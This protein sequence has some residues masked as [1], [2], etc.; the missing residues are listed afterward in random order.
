MDKR[1]IIIA[2]ALIAVLAIVASGAGL[3]MNGLYKN[4]T[5]SG[6]AQEQGND[7]VTLVLCVPLLAVSTYYAARGSLRG[8]LVWTGMVFYF[9]YVYAMMSF[10]SAYNQLFLV[11]VAAFSLSLYTFAYSVLTLDVNAVKESFSGAPTKAAAGFMFLIAIAVSAMWLGM[12]VPSL[13][14]GERPVAL[15]TYTTLVVQALDLGVIVPLSLIAGVLLLQKKA[16]GYALASLIFV[17]GITLGTAVLS[18]ALFM[19]LNGVEVVLPQ[20]AIFVLLVLGALALAIIFY[21]KMKVPAA[22]AA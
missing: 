19:S 2:S 9:L 15:E 14:T 17:K 7:L 1:I 16:W 10:L 8:R 4:D 22:S 6:A 5:K 12:I 21:G 11:Y 20:V 3:F 13:L 18:M